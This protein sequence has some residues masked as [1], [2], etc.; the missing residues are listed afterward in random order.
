MTKKWQVR[1]SHGMLKMRHCCIASANCDT[2]SDVYR[3]RTDVICLKQW[4]KI[5]SMWP[6]GYI[7]LTTKWPTFIAWG[8][9][10]NI[11]GLAIHAPTFIKH[12][13]LIHFYNIAALLP[14][15]AFLLYPPFLLLSL[16]W[17]HFRYL[18]SICVCGAPNINVFS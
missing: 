3:G 12:Y 6:R 10:N 14:F 2:D 13:L 1:F 7:M 18:A 16:D 4:R 17:L 5:L 11:I 8:Q 15:L 9:F